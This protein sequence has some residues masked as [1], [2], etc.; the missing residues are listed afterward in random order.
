MEEVAQSRS[1]LLRLACEWRAVVVKCRNN[2]ID[3]RECFLADVSRAIAAPQASSQ[4]LSHSLA[5]TEGY[6][7][8]AVSPSVAPLDQ[9]G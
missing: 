7:C 8:A 5:W 6:S 1:E 2:H 4:N 3:E 9:Q